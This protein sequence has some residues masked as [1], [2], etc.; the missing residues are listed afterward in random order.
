MD[1]KHL[2][3][4]YSSYYNT[5]KSYMYLLGIGLEVFICVLEVENIAFIFYTLVN[6]SFRKVT[7]PVSTGPY[8]YKLRIHL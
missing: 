7:F 1:L 3:T 6:L 8:V 5:I 4:P 2:S